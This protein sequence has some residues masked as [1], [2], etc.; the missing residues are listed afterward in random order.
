MVY[1]RVTNFTPGLNT[2]DDARRLQPN[3]AKQS[4]AESPLMRNVEINTSGALESSKG[5]SKK[6]DLGS[7]N[8]VDAMFEF[9]PDDNTSFIMA[10]SNGKVYKINTADDTVVE[11]GDIPA[12]DVYGGVQTI[13]GGDKVLVIGSDNGLVKVTADAVVALNLIDSHILGTFNGRLFIGKGFTVHY[14]PTDSLANVEGTTAF[15]STIRGLVHEG[16]RLFVFTDIAHQNLFFDYDDQFNVSTP[17]K[18]SFE[19]LYGSINH[20]AFANILNDTFYIGNDLRVYKVG[21][22][23]FTDELGVPRTSSMSDNVDNA[24]ANINNKVAHVATMKY[25]N[26]QL[27]ISVPSGSSIRNNATYIWN[28]QWNSWSYRDGFSPSAY[29]VQTGSDGKQQLYFSDSLS[30]AVFAFDNNHSYDGEP[31]LA[32]WYS[33]KFDFGDATLFKEVLWIDLSGAMDLSTTLYCQVIADGNVETFVIDRD[34]VEIISDGVFV[35]EGIIGDLPIGD[36]NLA[37]FNLVTND[38]K[39]FKSHI[40]LPRKLREAHEFQIRIF[41]EA[42]G[43]PWKVDEIGIEYEYRPRKQRN[44]KYIINKTTS[45]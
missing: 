13:D 22:E 24:L 23:E 41:N 35:A 11:L 20:Q 2:N 4:A 43:Q 17:L 36:D 7:N 27:F 8:V 14:T 19:R 31:F 45:L 34:N 28:Q 9:N 1:K 21:A 37:P 44:Q 10:V 32:E 33:K 16:K 39:R 5:F 42:V 25:L 40:Q 18:D 12:A 3:S 15:S 6:Y 29:A 30:E 26:K 38:L